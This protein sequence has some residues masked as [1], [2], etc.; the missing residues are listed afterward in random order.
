MTEHVE[1]YVV[2]ISSKEA[3]KN[4]NLIYNVCMEIEGQDDEWFGYGWDKPEFFKEDKIEFDIE[5][6]GEYCN[7]DPASVNVLEENGHEEEAKP[8]RS[9]G[10]SSGNSRGSSSR[11]SSRSKPASS[12][13]SSRSKPAA[14]KGRAK[15]AAK[16]NT[17]AMSKDEWA[18]KDRMIRRQACMN[19]A[20][21]L[22]KLF[23]E[24]G[25]LPKPKNK[26]AGEDALVAL[27]D[28]EAN[29][30]YDQYEEQVYGGSKPA[31]RGSKRNARE[32][33]DDDIPE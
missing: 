1:G 21:S 29:R 9:S 7:I 32:D 3:G 31:K 19:T 33:F 28:E 5:M 12:R 10:R 26:G 16:G 20:I 11:G 6:N 23:N 22:V 18:D 13:G 17:D 30:L 14:S 8:A 4:H 2:Q 27:C 24:A 15:P 25:V